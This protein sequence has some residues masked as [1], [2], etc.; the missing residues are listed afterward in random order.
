[1]HTQYGL[2]VPP[3]CAE[4]HHL[5]RRC[6]CVGLGRGRGSL[7]YSLPHFPKPV[8][9]TLSRCAAAAPHRPPRSESRPH[10][11]R[12]LPSFTYPTAKMQTP[13]LVLSESQHFLPSPLGAPG[14][15]HR[16]FHPPDLPRSRRRPSRAPGRP[17]LVGMPCW[18]IVSLAFPLTHPLPFSYPRADTNTQ[19]E[20]GRKAQ[21][22][23]IAA[24]K[25]R[26]SAG[27][28]SSPCHRPARTRPPPSACLGLVCSAR[29]PR[30]RWRGRALVVA[31]A[32]GVVFLEDTPT[33]PNSDLR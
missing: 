30:C 28:L 31:R 1:M 10:A 29:A 20:T 25:V 8:C 5:P 18:C 22:A 7:D 6:V 4:N 12:A 14:A 33:P 17:P 13:V 26:D 27:R 23:N 3:L 15:N 19:R 11:S 24:A 32:D 21:L 2:L 9:P 16:S